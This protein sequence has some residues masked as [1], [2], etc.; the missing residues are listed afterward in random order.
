M[1]SVEKKSERIRQLDVLSDDGEW[2]WGKVEDTL[3][4]INPQAD[5]R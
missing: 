4:R 1:C 2:Q 3:G 5:R